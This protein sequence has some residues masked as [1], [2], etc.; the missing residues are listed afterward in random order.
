MRS[1]ICLLLSMMTFFASAKELQMSVFFGNFYSPETGPYLETYFSVYSPSL[2]FT[3]VNSTFSGGVDVTVIFEKGDNVVHADRFLLSVNDIQDTTQPKTFTQQ[4]RSLLDTGSYKMKLLL[5]DINN[6]DQFYELTQDVVV[7]ISGASPEFSHIQVLDSY[8]ATSEE[9]PMT[10]SG[11]RLI[12]YV[13]QGSYFFGESMDKLQFYTELYLPSGSG[14]EKALVRY[15][16]KDAIKDE[17]LT[18]FAGQ[19]LINLQAVNPFLFGMDISKL[20]SGSY[21][22]MIEAVNSKQEILAKNSLFFYRS[23]PK[24]DMQ[25]YDYASID[26]NSLFATLNNV[27]SLGYYIE[28]LFPI[29]DQQE[30]RIIDIQSKSDNL[31]QMRAFFFTFWQKRNKVDPWSEWKNYYT[32]VKIV[33][34]NY[35]TTVVP[36]FKTDMGRVFLQYGAPTLREAQTSDP[37]SYPYEIWQYN[38]LKSAST[39]DQ[40]NKIFVFANKRLGRNSYQ[41]IHSTADSEPYNPRWQLELRERDF[42]TRDPDFMGNMLRDD[43]G[44][45]SQ[46]NIIINGGAR[47]RSSSYFQN[48]M[49]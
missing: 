3:K 35:S 9:G 16:L 21:Y 26:A 24:F 36:G 30:R 34:E 45:R 47:E 38:E 27:D 49:R 6:P 29:A 37:N 5:K 12:P 8:V 31:I 22:L 32:V 13:P 1:G 33:N 19:K 23:N 18:R 15:F 41:L 17:P 39:R 14:D 48:T 10:K 4:I 20:G 42:R 44:E 11:Y 2:R 46:N 7:N 43:V 40:I 25:A 28:T